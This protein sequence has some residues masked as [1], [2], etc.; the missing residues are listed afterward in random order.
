MLAWL[1]QQN[2]LSIKHALMLE[3]LAVSA[4]TLP[5]QVFAGVCAACVH[6]IKR[7]SDL[8]HCN[9]I[10]I[11]EDCAI[12]TSLK[13]DGKTKPFTWCIPLVGFGGVNWVVPW[14]TAVTEA[15]LPG[16]DYLVMRPSSSFVKFTPSIADWADANRALHALLVCAGVQVGEVLEYSMHS[17]RHLGPTVARQLGLDDETVSLMGGWKGRFPMPAHYDSVQCVAELRPKVFCGHER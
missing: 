14:A 5:L 16:A 4:P 12:L 17:M 7:W 13:S 11:A 8:R 9:N 10:E 2:M 3:A 6:G 15:G 1:F